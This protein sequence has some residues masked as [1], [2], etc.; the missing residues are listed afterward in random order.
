MS[1]IIKIPAEWFPILETAF[2]DCRLMQV[3]QEQGNNSDNIH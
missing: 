3:I 1:R 2:F